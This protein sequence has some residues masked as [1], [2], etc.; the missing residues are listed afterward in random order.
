MICLIKV[1][2]FFSG[3]GGA[4][5]GFQKAGFEIALGIDIDSDAAETFSQNFPEAAFINKDIRSLTP[6]DICEYVDKESKK[7]F[8]GCAPCQPFSKQN[9]NKS[10]DDVRINLLDEFYRF[11]EFYLPDYLFIENVPGIQKFEMG[12][13]PLENFVSKLKECGYRIKTQV[14][15]ASDYGVPQIRKR[16]ILIGALNKEVYFPAPTHGENRSQ[17]ETVFSDWVYE[18]PLL[19]AGE[20]D[21]DDPDHCA[22]ALTEKNLMRIKATPEGGSRTDWS[23]N[24]KLDCHKNHVGH[25]DVYGRLSRNKKCST[26]TTKCISYSNGRYGHPVENRA[27][28]VREAACLQTFDRTFT[29]AGKL[30]SKAKQVGN[31][32]PPLLAY[33]FGIVFNEMEMSSD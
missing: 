30:G 13:S 29:F 3:C 10:G 19:E 25:T 22:A 23:D 12:G 28:S 2:D 21:P 24:L 26:L 7:L 31:A 17:P 9:R 16:L 14:I 18:L 5:S 33:N 6:E 15:T 4:S 27:L 1:Y 32:V 11:I 20:T 8:C